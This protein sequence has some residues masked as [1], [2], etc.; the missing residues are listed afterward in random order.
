MSSHQQSMKLPPQSYPVVRNLFAEG[1][2][3]NGATGAQA[4]QG[5]ACAN[6]TGLAQQ[7]CY[8]TR[9]GIAV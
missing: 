2:H 1:V 8:A 9:Y 7:M 5:N 6:L 3:L 4:S